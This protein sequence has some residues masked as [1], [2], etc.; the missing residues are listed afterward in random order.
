MRT[1]LLIALFV[2]LLAGTDARGDVVNDGRYAF[3]GKS[4]APSPISYSASPYG[5]GTSAAY[6]YTKRRD[7]TDPDW[8]LAGTANDFA[9]DFTY[10]GDF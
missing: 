6:G 7:L 1:A 8:G 2:A 3:G 4:G 10:D 9:Y 5:N